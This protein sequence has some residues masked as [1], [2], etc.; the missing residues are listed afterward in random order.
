MPISPPKPTKQHWCAEINIIPLE[1][2]KSTLISLKLKLSWNCEILSN[3][4]MVGL[5]NVAF[6]VRSDYSMCLI[7]LRWLYSKYKVEEGSW[8]ILH[9]HEEQDQYCLLIEAETWKDYCIECNMRIH[10]DVRQLWYYKTIKHLC[11]CKSQLPVHGSLNLPTYRKATKKT[12]QTVLILS[13]WRI[14]RQLIEPKQKINK[15]IH[16]CLYACKKAKEREREPNKSLDDS[17]MLIAVICR[18]NTR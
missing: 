9:T 12:K 10:E 1:F 11:C 6:C 2:E 17:A 14:D 13:L 3:E 16:L 8:K 15:A 18:G 5:V 7:Y 4:I